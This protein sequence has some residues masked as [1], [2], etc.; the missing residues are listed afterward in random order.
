MTNIFRAFLILFFVLIS[1]NV[2]S[3]KSYTSVDVRAGANLSEMAGVR[4]PSF[5]FGYQVAVLFDY[6]FASNIFLESGMGFHHKQYGVNSWGTWG[7]DSYFSNERTESLSTLQVPVLVGYRFALENNSSLNIAL[8]PY[9][10]YNLSGGNDNFGGGLQ[11]TVGAAFNKVLINLGY[12]Y[13]FK[14]SMDLNCK[15]VYLTLGYKIF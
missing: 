2:F 6:N 14:D 1:F 8:G 4:G 7:Y 15:T 5:K 12:E 3:Q 11:A 10:A 9:A 13:G